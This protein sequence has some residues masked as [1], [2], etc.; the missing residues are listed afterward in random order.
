M[1]DFVNLEGAPAVKA[2]QQPVVRHGVDRP[3]PD[4]LAMVQGRRRGQAKPA[5]PQKPLEVF[6]CHKLAV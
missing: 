2:E 4:G 3:A 6:G 1:G 5:V